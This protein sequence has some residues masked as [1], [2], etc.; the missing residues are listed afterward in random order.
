[1]R[2]ENSIK[3]EKTD[4]VRRNGSTELLNVGSILFAVVC[5]GLAP[6]ATRY[7]LQV[8]TPLQLVVVRYILSLLFFVPTLFTLRKGRW[9]RR[10]ML[11]ALLCG[12]ANIL[13][14]NLCVAYGIQHIPASTASFILATESIWIALFS[15][16]IFHERAHWIVFLGFAVSTVGIGVLIGWQSFGLTAS[17]S[18]STYIGAGLTLLA[19]MMWGIYTLAV[20][21]L[22][23]KYGSL[24]STSITTIYGTIP[25]F[26]GYNSAV[27][28]HLQSLGV[29]RWGALLF[30]VLCSTILA[31]I[32]WN[33][34]VARLPGT[35]VS[36]F[37]YLVPCVGAA[38][39]FLLL[40]ETLTAGTLFGGLLI[41]AG[42]VFAQL[43][44]L[45]VWRNAATAM[46]KAGASEH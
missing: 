14:Y 30:L 27:I 28:M 31:F 25:L 46:P 40:H 29:A 6:V 9:N 39:G 42:V 8:F 16:L 26:A 41:I 12:L 35:Q 34:A 1:M 2:F 36:L 15:L 24:A 3:E 21:P 43:P 33:Y 37:L 44:Q 38:G 17:T 5:W 18:I 10:A 45:R 13:G 20:R 22:S 11:R 7:L 23:Q 32:L 19:A 4:M